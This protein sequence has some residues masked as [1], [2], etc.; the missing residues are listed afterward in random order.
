MR[1]MVMK[2]STKLGVALV[3]LGVEFYLA[4]VIYRGYFDKI[5]VILHHAAPTR[6]ALFN[7]P[8]L[9]FKPNVH[10][11]SIFYGEKCMHFFVSN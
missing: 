1:K 3:D 9:A 5:G 8:P 6:P 10:I 11:N 4:H 2:A 7:T